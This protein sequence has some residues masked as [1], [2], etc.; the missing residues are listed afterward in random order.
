MGIKIFKITPIIF[1]LTFLLYG[2]SSN[3][4]KF[5]VKELNISFQNMK[6]TPNN[7]N[8]VEKSEINLN[9]TSDVEG[10]LHIHGYNIKGEISKNKVSKITINLNATGSFPIAFHHEANHSEHSSDIN[11]NINKHGALFE[12]DMI[13]KGESFIYN[14]SQELSGKIIKFHDHMSHTLTGEIIVMEQGDAKNVSIYYE[15]KRFNPSNVMVA[16]GSNITWENNSD[17]KI[18]IISGPPPGNHDDE[19][20][21]HDTQEENNKE[22]IVGKLLVNPK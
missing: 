20:D 3:S 21:N 10:T 1:L 22:T 9:I 7:I 4:E 2:C 6:L 16:P 11:N 17:D 19:H 5:T 15:N 14:I 12:S 18:K 8:V 13:M